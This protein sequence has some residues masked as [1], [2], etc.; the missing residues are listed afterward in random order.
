MESEMVTEKTAR[1]LTILRQLKHFYLSNVILILLIVHTNTDINVCYCNLINF[2]NLLIVLLKN[3]ISYWYW[4]I[5]L[6]TYQTIGISLKFH[7]ST[8]L[9]ATLKS[10]PGPKLEKF[11]SQVPATSSSSQSFFYMGHKSQTAKS[12]EMILTITEEIWLISSSPCF[13]T[14]EFSVH[15]QFLILLTYPGFVWQQWD[16]T[17]S[18]HYGESKETDVGIELEPVLNGEVLKKE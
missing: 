10:T 12:N 9:L 1:Q 16:D 14:V 13:Q 15:F 2:I 6:N 5:P 3:W 11:L 18:I 4:Q 8:T 7:I 17:L